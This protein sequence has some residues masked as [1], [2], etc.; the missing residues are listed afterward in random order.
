MRERLG[1]SEE[2]HDL[3]FAQFGEAKLRGLSDG[4]LRKA[5]AMGYLSNNEANQ[6]IEYSKNLSAGNK[7]YLKMKEK[8]I[9]F[10][11][12]NHGGSLFGGTQ[13]PNRNTAVFYFREESRKV[14]PAAD[15]FQRQIDEAARRAMLRAIEE[16]HR[17]GVPY[18]DTV[19]I[20]DS[21]SELGTLK[22]AVDSIEF[23]EVTRDLPPRPWQQDTSTKDEIVEESGTEAVQNLL[24]DILE[25]NSEME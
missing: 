10:F 5:V 18:I 4:E 2:Q 16:Q 24:D 20:W 14:D 6:I 17:A 12:K 1:I 21:D 8:N 25:L 11:L 22:K 9:D 23:R 13:N 3:Y 15:D 7:D 19:F